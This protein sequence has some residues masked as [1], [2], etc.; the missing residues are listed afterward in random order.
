MAQVIIPGQQGFPD[1]TAA[2][3][4][5]AFGAER[6]QH[7]LL[8]LPDA[9]KGGS[10]GP[11]YVAVLLKKGSVKSQMGGVLGVLRAVPPVENEDEDKEEGG[12]E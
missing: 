12:R 11:T 3:A 5:D 9:P 7:G 4:L 6:T 2:E 1:S 8:C 10:A